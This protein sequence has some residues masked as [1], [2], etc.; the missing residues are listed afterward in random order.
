ML[1]EKSSEAA[2]SAQTSDL[3]LW[4]NPQ[5]RGPPHAIAATATIILSY[6][7]GLES[8]NKFVRILEESEKLF[9]SQV[10]PLLAEF[11]RLEHDR[12]LAG[13]CDFCPRI[14]T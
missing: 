8:R 6:R 9:Q 5:C 7:D 11:E 10:E 1:V 2:S 14:Y 13:K 3:I 4:D 12:N